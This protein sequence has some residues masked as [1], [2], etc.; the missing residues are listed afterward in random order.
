VSDANGVGMIRKHYGDCLRRLAGGLYLGRRMRE[1]DVDWHV[2][3]G[4]G[5]RGQIIDFIRPAKLDDDV[6]AFDPA[7]VT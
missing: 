4:G 3:E 2:G 7:E 6:L 5:E 1:Y